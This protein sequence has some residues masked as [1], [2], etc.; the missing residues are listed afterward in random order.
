[1]Q[2]STNL[3]R[4]SHW[5]RFLISFSM[6]ATLV[7]PYIF[8]VTL[9]FWIFLVFFDFEFVA[10]VNNINKKYLLV[11]LM[12]NLLALLKMDL[13]LFIKLNTIFLGVVY[14]YLMQDKIVDYLKI[15]FFISCLF[16]ILQ[17][18]LYFTSPSLALQFAG[19]GLSQNIW[20]EKYG[21]AGYA[22]QYVTLFLPRM[23]GLS[24][25]GGFFASCVSVMILI[26]IDKNKFKGKYKYL[27]ITAYILSLSK[28]S[29]AIILVFI[30]K[31]RPL[32]NKF[33]RMLL[34]L[35][36]SILF[37][38]IAN[39]LNINDSKFIFAQENESIAH[40][41]S[42]SYMIQHF[43]Y[44]SLALGC[45]NS[46]KCVDNYVEN[47]IIRFAAN[48]LEP[49]QGINGI[50]VLTGYLGFLLFLFSIY[51]FK[52]DT[53]GVLTIVIFTSSI[54]FITTDNFIILAYYYAYSS[55]LLR[56]N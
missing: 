54:T 11:M 36:F 44:D 14:L 55:S 33:P 23:S 8:G 42:S 10:K 31:I 52:I 46:F 48:G 6:I 49:I 51:I 56:K 1:M 40:R 5:N 21:T 53:F 4:F 18:I 43:S 20:G 29:I 32:I 38:S 19:Q 25:E 2:L 7:N 34:I 17:F 41:L 22:N 13:V 50:I 12:W 24:R 37:V 16:C 3:V 26:L 28:S 45:D 39:H 27:S 47:N 35:V 9:Y 15:S 30:L